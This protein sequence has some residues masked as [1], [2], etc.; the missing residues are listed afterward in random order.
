MQQ[1]SKPQKRA[2]R[3]IIFLLVAALLYGVLTDVLSVNNPA[4]QR[5]IRGFYYEPKNSLDVVMIG[6]SE[7]YTGFCA[8]LA[9]E[10]Y[11]FTSYP[12]SVSSMPSC[13][14]RSMLDETLR[15]QKPKVIVV[16]INAF[17]YDF[18]EKDTRVGLHKW[19]DNMPMSINKVRAIQSLVPRGERSPYYFRME[20]YHKY[21]RTPSVWGGALAQRLM[22]QRAGGSLT[23]GLEV[24]PNIRTDNVEPKYIDMSAENEQ[25]LRDFCAYA[26][27]LGV[28]NLLFVRFPHRSMVADPSVLPRMAQVIG[29]CGYPFLDLDTDAE[30]LGLDR[31]HDFG[32]TEHMNVFGMEKFTA[33]FGQY[34]TEHYDLSGPHSD[35]VAAR[36]DRCADFVD[37]MLPICEQKTPSEDAKTCL[38]E[39]SPE[40][41]AYR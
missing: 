40:L 23:K 21:W 13:L 5:H 36:W 35:R 41:L 1:R 10:Q 20:K 7:L 27:S 26:K 38:N 33:W 3:A 11:G 4:D 14:Y 22:M 19:I 29:E 31:Y 39:F 15:R 16:E 9:W 30:S 28:E 37:K 34:L 25:I 8:P 24:I 6:A 17:L 12:L 18:D 32:D 2:L